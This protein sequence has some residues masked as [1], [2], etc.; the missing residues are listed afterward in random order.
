MKTFYTYIDWTIEPIPRAFYIGKGQSGRVKDTTHRSKLWKRIAKKYGHLRE[1]IFATSIEQLAFDFEIEL[2]DT[3]KTFVFA[4][5]FVFGANF[6][7]GGEG[8]SGFVPSNK[9]RQLWSKMRKGK[10][11]NLT[12]GQRKQRKKP[13]TK[14]HRENQSKSLK[15]HKVTC[16]ICKQVGHNRQVCSLR[17]GEKLPTKNKNKRKTCSICGIEGHNKSSCTNAKSK[18]KL[19]REKLP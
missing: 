9:T 15:N 17:E 11:L 10:K 18:R 6:T 13:K 5:D 14:S 12:E 1:I 2:I 4:K 7:K 19:A 16:S 3:Y 8:L